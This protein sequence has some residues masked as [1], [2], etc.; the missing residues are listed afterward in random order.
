MRQFVVFITTMF[1]FSACNKQP[2]DLISVHLGNARYYKPFL[3][4][5]SDTTILEK[6]FHFE[7]ND[8]AK[9]KNAK[10]YLS[11]VDSEGNSY[12]G[13]GNNL[14]LWYNGKRLHG[15]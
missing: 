10:V 9:E 13:I 15:N 14:I 5:K 12:P 4:V 6:S 7:F 2:D 11:I 8:Y 3:W 1:I